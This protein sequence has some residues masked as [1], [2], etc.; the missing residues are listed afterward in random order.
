M[1]PDDRG[2]AYLSDML[3]FAAEV[4]EFTQGAPLSDYLAQ[5]MKRRATE[6]SIELLGRLE[7]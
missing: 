1:Q 2:A 5:R 3:A 7:R 6:R 4:V